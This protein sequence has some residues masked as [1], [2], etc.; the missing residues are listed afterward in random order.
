MAGQYSAP[1][2]DAARLERGR[3]KGE[4]QE[5]NLKKQKL[6]NF[7][8][9]AFGKQQFRHLSTISGILLGIGLLGLLNFLKPAEAHA[10]EFPALDLGAAK[11]IIQ[12]AAPQISLNTSNQNAD[13]SGSYLKKP[14][15]SETQI[16]PLD[17]PKKPIIYRK[18]IG[19]ASYARSTFPSQDSSA[20][21]HRFPYGYCTYYVA[22]HR[23]VPWSGNAISWLW[24]ARSFGF[25]TGSTPRANA[26]MVTTEGG[27]TGHVALVNSV[28]DDGTIT[29][30]EM[31]YSGWGVV[32]S[33]TIA[34]TYG[35]IMGYIY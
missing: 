29:V 13:S 4:K 10:A 20:A 34:E 26:I 23:F 2:K 3:G 21:N 22:E 6:T 5:T 14:L 8:K 19:L 9:L 12:N 25:A 1:Q 31:N 17:P 35:P 28:N 27:R 32:S 16:T 7:N 15:I 24:G 30:T 33:R 11:E 18:R